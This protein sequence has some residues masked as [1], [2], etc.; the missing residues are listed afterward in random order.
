MLEPNGQKNPCKRTP[1]FERL[2]CVCKE[3][4]NKIALGHNHILC[5]F[6][7]KVQQLARWFNKSLEKIFLGRLILLSNISKGIT[8]TFGNAGFFYLKTRLRTFLLKN[9]SICQVA[10]EVSTKS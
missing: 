7:S 2:G 9:T 10:P 4:Q 8:E 5:A 3:V 1:V 6:D